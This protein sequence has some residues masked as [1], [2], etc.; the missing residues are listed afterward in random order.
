MS[1]PLC[2][3]GTSPVKLAHFFWKHSVRPGDTVID[4]TC[5]RGKDSLELCK[6][7]LPQGRFVGYDIQSSAIEMTKKRLLD[8]GC[9]MNRIKL[10][11][12]SHQNIFDHSK[13]FPEWFTNVS[14]VSFNLGYLPG[15]DKQITTYSNSTMQAI[16]GASEILMPGGT[17]SIVQYPHEEGI[18]EAQAIQEYCNS[19]KHTEWAVSTHFVPANFELRPSLIC[20]TKRN[21]EIKSKSESLEYTGL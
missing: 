11:Q 4:A 18:K 19:L 14:L 17:I 13:E 16:Q 15:G 20:I 8:H 12:E 5:G 1:R 2:T 9:D 7:V 6:I 3:I 21:P 10:F